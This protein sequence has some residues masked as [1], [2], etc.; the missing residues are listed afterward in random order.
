MNIGIIQGRLSE[1]VNGHI[2]E[3]PENWKQEFELLHKCGLS[4]IEWLITKGTAKSNPAFNETISLKEL[5]ISS[6]CADTLVDTRVTNEK[7]LKEHLLP[8]CKSA[9][10]N[11]VDIITIP[12]LE[13]SSVEDPKVRETFKDLISEYAKQYPSLK[14]SFECEL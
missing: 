3:F 8:I 1:P 4:H 10:R 12:L 9:V 11:N 6:Y 5:P 2:Q 13:D 7:Y 14:F